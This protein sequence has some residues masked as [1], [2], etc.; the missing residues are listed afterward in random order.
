MLLYGKNSVIERLRAAP[1]TMRQL[2][3]C[4][5]FD[6]PAVME[7]IRK[8]GV[9]VQRL[10]DKKFARFRPGENLQG[11]T[12]EVEEFQYADLQDLLENKKLVP[13]FLDR[14]FDPQNLGA[15]MRSAACF[16]GFGIVIPGHKACSV[17]ETV[18]K[19]ACGAENYLPVAQPA[20]L[21]NAILEAKERGFWIA[22]AGAD[23]DKDIS[24]EILPF[25]LALV[26][27]SEGEGVR[28]GVDKHL[29]LRLRIPMPG[30][31]LSLNVA[32]ACAICCYEIVRQRNITVDP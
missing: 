22:G 32:Q 10:A 25:P 27:G 11:I 13:I 23:A 21:T 17:T 29:D 30:A 19:V 16:G 18:L 28:Y 12:A 4:E 2:F 6:D 14:V 7:V 3:L 1:A 5:D 20:N 31:G 8:S 24:R 9:K 15:I 26:L